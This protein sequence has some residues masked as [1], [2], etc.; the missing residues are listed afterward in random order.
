[1]SHYPD[2]RAAEQ[3]AASTEQQ[4]DTGA[5]TPVT[6]PVPVSKTVLW[7]YLFGFFLIFIDWRLA[8]VFW[9]VATSNHLLSGL[10]FRLIEAV[11]HGNSVRGR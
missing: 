1:M 3:A 11:E 9:L 10:L 2:E 6:K 5:T 8:L 4:P 7:Q